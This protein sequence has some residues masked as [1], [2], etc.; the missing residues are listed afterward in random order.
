ME[1][2]TMKIFI[3]NLP[4]HIGYLKNLKLIKEK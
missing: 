3:Q 4:L 1:D 2:I